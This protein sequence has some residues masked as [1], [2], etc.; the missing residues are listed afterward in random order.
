MDVYCLPCI[1]ILVSA[2]S[3]VALSEEENSMVYSVNRRLNGDVY[4]TI[5]TV[6]N[7]TGHSVCS[8][9]G[10]L[11]FLVS[12]RRCVNN[13][14]FFNGELDMPKVNDFTTTVTSD[15]NFTIIATK[16]DSSTHR[17]VLKIKYQND[18]EMITA[19]TP[20]SFD[21]SNLTDAVVYHRPTG[22]PVKS[23]FC[24][25]SSLEVYR[26]KNKAIK[27]RHNGFHLNQR[28]AIEVR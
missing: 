16:E 6:P 8:D 15:C 14:E 28:G 20:F 21:T 12:D 25:I 4:N 13:E 9:D 11:T 3:S 1:L 2:L 22:Q 10:N 27:I 7:S 17:L 24:Q 19:A 23:A 26:G 5:I 18:T